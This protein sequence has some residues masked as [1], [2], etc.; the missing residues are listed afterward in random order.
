[1]S[2]LGLMVGRAIDPAGTP[3]LIDLGRVDDQ[4]TRDAAD[5]IRAAGVGR[6]NFSIEGAGRLLVKLPLAKAKL[7]DVFPINAGATYW[8]CTHHWIHTNI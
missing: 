4:R 7:L 8:Q 1:M 6:K 3:I 2:Q 5:K